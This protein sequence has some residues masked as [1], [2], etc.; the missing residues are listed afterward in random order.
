[1]ALEDPKTI[2]LFT[3]IRQGC[4]FHGFLLNCGEEAG[5]GQTKVDGPQHS[6]GFS[7]EHLL[8]FSKAARERTKTR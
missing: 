6:E 1:M 3:V 4:P 8:A 7:F 2:D 5:R